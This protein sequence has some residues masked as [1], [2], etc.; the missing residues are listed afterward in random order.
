MRAETIN[1]TS[2]TGAEKVGAGKYAGRLLGR[3]IGV[4]RGALVLLMSLPLAFSAFAMGPTGLPVKKI[5]F[6]S[7][8]DSWHAVDPKHVVVNLSP[9]KSYLLTLRRD[10]PALRNNADLGVTASNNTIYAGFDAVTVNG[11]SCT[12]QRINKLSQAERRALIET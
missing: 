10:C 8:I 6:A 11:R 2:K 5:P 12:I 1:K 4:R 9:T 7:S 3:P